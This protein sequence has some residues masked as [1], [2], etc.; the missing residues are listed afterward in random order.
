MVHLAESSQCLAEPVFPVSI[1]V[2]AV[3]GNLVR[4]VST[5]TGLER[6]QGEGED[7]K[8]AVLPRTTIS[9]LAWVA[10]TALAVGSTM[11]RL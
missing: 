9:S 10:L 2:G 6:R 8:D 3:A 4:S 1:F 11:T 5:N 7:G